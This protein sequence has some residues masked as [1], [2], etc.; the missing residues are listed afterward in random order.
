MV[1]ENGNRESF[2]TDRWVSAQILAAIENEGARKFFVKTSD[3]PGDNQGLLVGNHFHFDCCKDINHVNR[4]QLWIFTPDLSFS[5]SVDTERRSD[6]TRA[7]KVFWRTVNEYQ[8]TQ[9]KQDIS[10]EQLS[11]PIKV[12]NAIRQSL[13]TSVALLPASARTFKEW[14]IGL[15]RRFAEGDL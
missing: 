3:S 1:H 11:L 14:N 9:D 4:F 2:G 12:V 5:S 13:E 8:D 10:V 6:P 7:M 15:L